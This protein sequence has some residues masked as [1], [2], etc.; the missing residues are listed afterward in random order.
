MTD[1]D[2]AHDWSSSAS[3]AGRQVPGSFRVWAPSAQRVR[4]AWRTAPSRAEGYRAAPFEFSEL[5]AAGFEVLELAQ[6]PDSH[7]WWSLT[8]VPQELARAAAGGAPACGTDAGPKDAPGRLE[9][10]FLIDDSPALLPDPRGRRAPYGPHGPSALEHGADCGDSTADRDAQPADTTGTTGTTGTRVA[11]VSAVVAPAAPV[12]PRPAALAD[13][14]PIYELHIGT[15]TPAGTLDAAVERLDYLAHLGIGWVELLPVNAFAGLHNWGYDG[16]QWFAVAEPYGGPTAYRRFVEGAHARGLAVVQDVVFNHLGPSGNYLSAFGP[17]LHAAA[18]NPWGESINLDGPGS[19]EV[20]AYILDVLTMFAQDYGVDGF[21]LDAVH[22]LVDARA[23]PILEDMAILCAELSDRLGRPITLIAESDRNDPATIAKRRELGAGAGGLGLDG[24]WSDDFHHAVHVALT[25]EDVG[26]YGDFAAPGALPKVLQSG[27]FHDGTYSTFR[28]REHGRPLDLAAARPEQLV[29]SIQN[30]DQVGNR[31]AGDRL[32]QQTGAVGHGAEPAG[33]TGQE[34]AALG[35]LGVGATFLLLGPNSPMLFMG[36]EWAASTPWQFFTDHREEWLGEAVSQGRRGEFAAMGWDASAVPDPQDPQTFER[37]KLDWSERAAEP[38]ASMLRLYRRLI[39][40][41]MSRA[42][43]RGTRFSDVEVFRGLPAQEPASAPAAPVSQAAG[44]EAPAPQA[45]GT[46]AP[47][48]PAGEAAGL[49][50][51]EDSAATARAG[52]A[53][54]GG[55]LADAVPTSSEPN[56]DGNR[57]GAAPAATQG[58]GAAPP[59]AGIGWRIGAE[60][61]VLANP[62]TPGTSAAPAVFDLPRPVAHVLLDTA[63]VL[64]GEPAVRTGRAADEARAPAAE[65]TARVV[66]EPGRALAVQLAA[67]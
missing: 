16:V 60:L 34:A 28:G 45:G 42:E 8:A 15:F 58:G 26:Y 64:A 66:V 6:A 49:P 5:A 46:G 41:R 2:L 55:A 48:A 14:A 62:A 30:H 52:E 56:L 4:L 11:E 40:L 57:H 53:D 3:A 19:D 22:A 67:N 61:V 29:V 1:T 13:G 23:V 25:G 35:N 36:E 21:R 7:G 31:A 24:Q 33:A 38:H 20:R 9:Y 17:Y 12:P 44:S 10:G 18:S 27:F 39:G 65:G 50:L 51:P 59:A 37:S 43:Y 63:A 54:A 32:P 47:A